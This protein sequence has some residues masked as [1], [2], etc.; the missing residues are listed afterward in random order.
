MIVVGT[1]MGRIMFIVLLLCAVSVQAQETIFYKCTD[2]KGA[3]SM[4][5]GTPCAAGMKQEVRKVGEVKTV[6]APAAKPKTE[7]SPAPPPL[8]PCAGS[9]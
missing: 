7:E 2:A 6:A 4:Q 1:E 5:N 9:L 8:S 3:V